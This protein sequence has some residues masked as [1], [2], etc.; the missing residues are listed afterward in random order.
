MILL[1]QIGQSRYDWRFLLRILPFCFE[2]Q[3][4]TWSIAIGASAMLVTLTRRTPAVL[5]TV[6][7]L[8]VLAVVLP[9]PVF[10]LVTHNQELTVAMVV[11]V[12]SDAS[13]AKPPRVI[14]VVP[15][16]LDQAGANAVAVHVL[17]VLRKAGLPGSYRVAEVDR[18]GRGRKALQIIVLNPPVP[19]E[20]LLPQPDGT[21]LIYV[22]K[23]DGWHT[24]PAQA[25]TLGRSVEVRGPRI[26]FPFLATYC[27]PDASGFG[28]CPAVRPE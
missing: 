24:I 9:A 8:C 19:A 11:P 21:E 15:S 12:S 20:S 17:E 7:V 13:A 28:P 10:N 22:V 23:P 27:V 26:G 6:T 25:P 3:A 18:V 1:G 14:S 5:A 16:W 2:L 4:I